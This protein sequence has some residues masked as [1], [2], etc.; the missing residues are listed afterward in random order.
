MNKFFAL[1]STLV[2]LAAC[3]SP[4]QVD[5]INNAAPV[6]SPVMPAQ[7][8]TAPVSWTVLTQKQIQELAKKNDPKLVL[9]ALDPNNFENL[10]TNMTDIQRFMQEQKLVLIAYRNYYSGSNPTTNK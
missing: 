5:N 1:I 6:F 7:I 10:A 9:Y 2:L 8:V 3:A 4:L